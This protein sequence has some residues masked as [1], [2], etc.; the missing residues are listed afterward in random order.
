MI[1]EKTGYIEIVTCS[2]TQALFL[3]LSRSQFP[4][5]GS[6]AKV[7]GVK[8]MRELARHEH[9]LGLVQVASRVASTMHLETT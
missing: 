5:I 1:S 2:L 3:R 6:L 4:S 7:E 9:S 8:K